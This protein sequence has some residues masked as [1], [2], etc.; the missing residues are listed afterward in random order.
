MDLR[1]LLHTNHH[2]LPSNECL[3][4]MEWMWMRINVCYFLLL[5]NVSY[6]EQFVNNAKYEP[7]G[8]ALHFYTVLYEQKKNTN[9]DYHYILISYWI[10]I[11]IVIVIKSKII[12]NN[13]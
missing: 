3:L 5:R 13:G 10:E 1:R 8:M 12:I 2:I 11:W 4:W 6:A 9:D 7:H